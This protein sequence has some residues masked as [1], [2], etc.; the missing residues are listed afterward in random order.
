MDDYKNPGIHWTSKNNDKPGKWSLQTSRVCS[1]RFAGCCHRCVPLNCAVHS[2]V[3]HCP[4]MC[5]LKY[6]KVCREY[7]LQM[8]ALTS[9]QA[10]VHRLIL[11]ILRVSFKA[12]FKKRFI[13]CM[14]FGARKVLA[15]PKPCE[16]LANN[17]ILCL[18][19]H[20]SLLLRIRLES[21]RHLQPVTHIWYSH[22][23][24]GCQ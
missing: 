5:S 22:M 8:S 14:F 19:P 18:L 21:I 4:Q 3:L 23:M 9:E 1:A 13:V 24:M 17:V 6:Y 16:S 15:A 20:H 11:F 10:V 7:R 2:C 12:F